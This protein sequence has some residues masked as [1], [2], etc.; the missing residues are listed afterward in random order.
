MSSNECV[1]SSKDGAT[2][3]KRVQVTRMYHSQ[4]P[5]IDKVQLARHLILKNNRV[6]SDD[7][8]RFQDDDER[9]E[10]SR[11]AACKCIFVYVYMYMYIVR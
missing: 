3:H 4:C 11:L 6:A 8:H 10:K 1:T 7:M 5:L 9:V 2:T